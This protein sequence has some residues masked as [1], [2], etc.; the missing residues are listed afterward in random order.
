MPLLFYR[1]TTER[2]LNSLIDKMVKKS[3]VG[4]KLM[5][6][7]LCYD[8]KSFKVDWNMPF[9]PRAGEYQSVADFR[10]ER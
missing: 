8:L 10:S 7:A 2:F 1:T 4:N 5:K 3:Y 9:L 6:V